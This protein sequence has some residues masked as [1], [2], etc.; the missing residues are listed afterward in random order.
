MKKITGGILL[1]AVAAAIASAAAA[2]PPSPRRASFGFYNV[3]N[4]FDTVP[5]PGDREFFPE[6]SRRWDTGRYRRK[7]EAIASVIDD[8]GFDVLALAEIENETVVRDLVG[9]LADD[10]NYILL[11]GRDPRGINLAMIYKG[12]KFFPERAEHIRS[13]FSRDFLLV[14]GMLLGREVCFL[15]CHLPSK[16]NAGDMRRRA[17]RR[18][19]HASDSVRAAHPDA[20]VIVAGDFNSTRGEEPLRSAALAGEGA[21][22][23]A[24]GQWEANGFGSYAWDGR[25]LLYDN[26]FVAHPLSG[27]PAAETAGAGI[28]IRDYMLVPDGGENGKRRGLP[29]RTFSGRR[30]EGGFSDHLPVFVIL[31]CGNRPLN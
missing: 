18:L 4:M 26:I 24:L 27:A 14:S 29:A 25:W 30:Y 13:G 8:A 15:V 22:A 11:P 31:E 3:E 23:C 16:Y 5:A 1:A 20:T 12:D 6:G 9:T 10:Y 28:F 21:F 2:P 17:V 7:V 19:D